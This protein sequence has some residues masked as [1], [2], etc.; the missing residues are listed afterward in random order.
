MERKGKEKEIESDWIYNSEDEYFSSLPQGFKFRRTDLELLEAYLIKKLKNQPLPL[1]RIREVDLYS[2]ATPQAL[3]ANIKLIREKKWY[4]FTP[5]FRK[6]ANGDRPD[7]GTPGGYWKTTGADIKVR[8]HVGL[9]LGTKRTLCFHEGKPM[10][11]EKTNWIM[12]EYI[13]DRPTTPHNKPRKLDEWV[14][15]KVFLRN[16][17]QKKD[18]SA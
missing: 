4:F 7:R 10:A 8:N 9:V 13:V 17:G 12:H 3:T 2:F 14:L 15:C 16:V 5:R 18:D 11:G 1:N 6:Y